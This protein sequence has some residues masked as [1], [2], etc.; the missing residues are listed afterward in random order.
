MPRFI[1]PHDLVLSK[2]AA[3]RPKDIAFAAGLLDM[4]LVDLGVLL[5]R[6]ESLPDS[7]A[8]VRQWLGSYRRPRS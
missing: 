2:P 7:G 5:D 8:R 6:V 1:E 4:R 3:G